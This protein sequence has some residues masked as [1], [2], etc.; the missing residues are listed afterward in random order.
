M[1]R[2]LVLLAI[3]VAACQQGSIAVTRGSGGGDYHH[4]AL[5][6]AIDRFVAA[7]R[8][9]DAYA[10]LAKTVA[11]LRPGMDRSVAD[12]SERKLI[13]IALDPVKAVADKPMAEQAA[14]LATTVW[15]TLL[16]PAIE[17]DAL[18]EVRD[19]KAAD[20]VPRP[21]EDA[22]AYLERI[23]GDVLAATCKHAVPEYQPALVRA[24]AIRRAT[25]R[26]RTAVEDCMM[27]GSD[28]G[29]RAAVAG[30]EALDREASSAVVDQERR[31]DHENWPMSGAASDDDP[32]LPEAELDVHGDVVVG[33]HAYG[34]NQLRID[35]LRELRGSGDVIA[36]HV[37]PDTSLAEVR[38]VLVDARAAGLLARGGRRARAGVSVAAADLLG[39]RRYRHAREPAPDRHAAAPA[40]RDRRGR[41]AGHRGAGRLMSTGDDIASPGSA[42]AR[43]AADGRCEAAIDDPRA[44]AIEAERAL[45]QHERQ[46]GGLHMRRG[47]LLIVSLPLVFLLAVATAGALHSI[48]P[49]FFGLTYAVLGA[50]IGGSS[51]ARGV[52]RARRAG[53]RLRGLSAVAQLPPARVL[54]RG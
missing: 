18:L 19:P 32:G 53:K 31:A 14:A 26:A 7:G 27:C 20:Y 46:A 35:V 4:G 22:R 41:R 24:L 51:V 36:L 38:A 34:P 6:A 9:A 42:G 47:A 25:E 16:E 44:R 37:L 23:C 54:K 13:V 30:W 1:T 48:V 21:G 40:P 3:A 2:L 11:E 52:S 49:V 29:W 8:T 17:A 45:W 50:A 15:P 5:V 43:S 10:V 28:A 12:E 39:R 33:G